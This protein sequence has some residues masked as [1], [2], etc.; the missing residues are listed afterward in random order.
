MGGEGLK[1]LVVPGAGDGKE[2][3]AGVTRTWDN[4][5]AWTNTGLFV[6]D[7]EW[8]GDQM[9]PR[10]KLAHAVTETAT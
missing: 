10:A 8:V 5:E 1:G 2:Q 7:I 4:V 9:R 6:K 3:A